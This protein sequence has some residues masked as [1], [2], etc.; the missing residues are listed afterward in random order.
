MI[1]VD[2]HCHFDLL[3]QNQAGNDAQSII[4]RAQDV[5]VQYFL[6]VCVD[7]ATVTPVLSV[8]EQYDFVYASVGV[9]PNHHETF[10]REQL[11][12]YAIHP[13]VI[14]IGETGLDYYRTTDDHTWQ[15]EQFRLH[16]EVAQSLKKPLIIH[17]RA[18]QV[19]TIKIMKETNA[20]DACGVMHCF[21][22]D[23]D[24]AKASLDLGFYISISGIVTFKNAHT[25]Q[26]VAQQIPLDRLLIET[27]SP[28]LAPEPKRGKPNEPAYV[29]HTAEFIA[30]LRGVSLE[31]IAEATTHNFFNLFKGAKH[32]HV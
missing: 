5:G 27:D 17:T 14:A 2:S 32:T 23:W 22:E 7:L 31:E 19:D 4:K 15:Q 21:T 30:N 20:Q 10:T 12:E 13:K 24:M 16:I 1:L 29:R 25:V 6:N 9:H 26:H 8:A 11:L 18:A 28:Y 3:D